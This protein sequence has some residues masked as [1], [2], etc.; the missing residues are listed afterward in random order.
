MGRPSGGSVLFWCGFLET[1][2]KMEKEEDL[3]L[4][5]EVVDA[6]FQVLLRGT[7]KVI[8]SVLR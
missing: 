5:L 7:L 4:K 6:E 8:C 1:S 3:E 2:K